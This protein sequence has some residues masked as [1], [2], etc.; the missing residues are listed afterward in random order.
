MSAG[1]GILFKK[2]ATISGA[3][4]GCQAEIGSACAMASAGLTS[5]LGGDV[6]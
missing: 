1:I 6:Y 5:V 2:G 4:G 3:E